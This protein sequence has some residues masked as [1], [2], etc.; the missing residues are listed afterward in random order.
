MEMVNFRHNLRPFGMFGVVFILSAQAEDLG[1]FG[2]TFEIAERD[3]LR[4][5]KEKLEQMAADGA[6]ER[7]Q[8]RMQKQIT[9]EAQHPKAVSGIRHTTVP[10]KFEF[11]PSVVV[12]RDLKDHKGKVFAKKGERFNPL[13]ILS[14]TKPLLFIYGDEEDHI[15][16]TK[17]RLRTYPTAKVILVRGSP[18][19]VEKKLHREI[20]FDQSGLMTQ[21][22]GIT[23]VPAIVYQEQGK[24]VL[25]VSET[26]AI[27]EK[28]SKFKKSEGKKP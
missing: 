9:K 8:Q 18:F 19:D 17:M 10:R 16:W 7:E 25:T 24:N 22:F 15:F 23:Q 3:L 26:L 5:I 11:D 14:M 20:Y 27:P 2:E 1:T 21:K 4:E 6:L 13:D 28:F 12:T